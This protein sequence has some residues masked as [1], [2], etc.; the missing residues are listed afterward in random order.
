METANER[1]IRVLTGLA[2]VTPA[3]R[4]YAAVATGL[5]LAPTDRQALDAAVIRL[6]RAAYAAGR[7]ARPTDE[8]EICDEDCER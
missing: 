3:L 7:R 8:T 5:G 2:D 4:G 1:D 6:Y